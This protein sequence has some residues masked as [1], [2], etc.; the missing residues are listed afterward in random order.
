MG[1]LL[2]NLYYGKLIPCERRSRDKENLRE[3]VQKIG[4]EEK[5]FAG[6]MSP[7]DSTRFGDLSD[8]YSK[9]SESEE[10]ESFAYGFSLGAL[11]VMNML[12]EADAM[13]P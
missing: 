9:L 2:H 4:E 5:Y 3:I 8:L 11:L 13:N 7:D 12:D 1:N 10:Y 6:K